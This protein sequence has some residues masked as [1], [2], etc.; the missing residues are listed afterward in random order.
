MRA[1]GSPRLAWRDLPD[2]LR[3]QID[4]ALDVRVIEAVDQGGG[5]TPGCAARVLGA[6][7]RRFFVKAVSETINSDSARLHR[8]E[9]RALS[10]LPPG[11]PIA[12][13][14]TLIDRDG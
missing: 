11:L 3:S 5:F 9:A 6:D 8:G 13:L 14:V 7:G 12:R 4:Q 2:P 10:Q 1:P